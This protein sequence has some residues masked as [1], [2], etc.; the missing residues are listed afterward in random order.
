MSKQK[1]LNEK[2][3]MYFLIILFYLFGLAQS[4]QVNQTL[5][6]ENSQ[7]ELKK[8]LEYLRDLVNLYYLPIIVSIGLIGNTLT[9]II[10]SQ[11][12]KLSNFYDANETFK[13]I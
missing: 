5:S 2:I 13:K 4:V 11:E 6:Q 10:L 1:K 9:I 8:K 7:E 3:R 12:N